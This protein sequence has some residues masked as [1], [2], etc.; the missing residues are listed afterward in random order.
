MKN[1]DKI[2]QISSKNSLKNKYEFGINSESFNNQ[3]IILNNFDNTNINYIDSNTDM[4][5]NKFK[6]N[7]FEYYN[8][9]Y[10]NI[11]NNKPNVNLKDNFNLFID[12]KN[13][14][15][16]NNDYNYN[17][18]PLK[19]PE[20]IRPRVIEKTID[21]NRK[22]INMDSLDYK[23]NKKVELPETDSLKSLKEILLKTKSD[24]DIL[25]KEFQIEIDN[26]NIKFKNEE[27][28]NPRKMPNVISLYK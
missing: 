23:K 8:S 15:N 1:L 27:E 4:L 26:K 10:E 22:I 13:Y 28:I 5:I 14:I 18:F 21:V 17:S 2:I 7:N 20:P 3:N 16:D 11:F 19:I 25:N 12:N 24:I 6:E 9:N